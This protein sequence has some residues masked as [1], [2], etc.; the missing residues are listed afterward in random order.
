MKRKCGKS[1][2]QYLREEES[3]QLKHVVPEHTIDNGDKGY[4][5][6]FYIRRKS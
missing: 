5:D 1:V 6:V 4:L 3:W 2:H